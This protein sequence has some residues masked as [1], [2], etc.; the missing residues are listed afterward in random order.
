MKVTA[1][2]F[3]TADGKAVTLYTMTNDHGH[4][5]SVMNWGATLLDVN[6]PDR[7]GNLANVNLRFDTLQ[8]YLTKHPYFGSTVG[9]FCNRIG[10]AKFTID[11]VEYPLSVN[12][13]KHQLH[14]GVQNF[15]FLLWD[16][17][18]VKSDDAV[19]VRMTLV[20]P[21]GQ[22]GF[23]GTVSAIV[24][25]RWN[26]ENELTVEFT[27]TTDKPTHVNLTNHSYWNLG[28]A[29]SGTA[30]D[31]IATIHADQWLD[32]DGDLIPTG[33]LND[34]EG[35]PLDFRSP[36]ALGDRIDQLPA[37]KGYDHC[38]VVRGSAGELR[39]AAHVIDPDSGRVLEIETT[40]PGMQLYTANHLPGDE[41]SAGNG[42]HDAFCLE[43][44]HYPDAPNKPSFPSTLLKPGETLRETTVHRFSV[45]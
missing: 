29:G 40:Q 10:N 34:V 23:P 18:S 37:T 19:A 7:D 11:G 28:G 44:Q 20:S 33:K 17:E 30:K 42:G 36:T 38:F 1:S 22:E 8:P 31:H 43:T 9:R 2:E 27:A 16:A 32:V 21:D 25:Y 5:V 6:V 41:G 35:T 12:H 13:G 4:S 26:N 45:Q 15:A 3:G 24:E 39:L 14:G